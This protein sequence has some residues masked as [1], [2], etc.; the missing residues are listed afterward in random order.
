MWL[1]SASSSPEGDL[2]HATNALTEDGFEVRRTRR[3]G[4]ELLVD[5]RPRRLSMGTMVRAIL[6]PMASLYGVWSSMAHADPF[7]LYGF[8]HGTHDGAGM[9]DVEFTEEP[10]FHVLTCGMVASAL[11]ETARCYGGFCATDPS[12][13]IDSCWKVIESTVEILPQLDPAVGVASEHSDRDGGPQ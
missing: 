6:G 12:A 7:T 11:K 4:I 8:A 5:G 10:A 9:V 1:W 2:D 13:T 3:G